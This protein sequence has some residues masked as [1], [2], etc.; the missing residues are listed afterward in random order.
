MKNDFTIAL[1]DQKFA[2]NRCNPFCRNALM[3]SGRDEKR[4]SLLEDNGFIESNGWMMREIV[5]I[6]TGIEADSAGFCLFDK[7]RP[8]FGIKGRLSSV[9]STSGTRR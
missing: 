3:M 1:H 5:E 4:G 2:L 8:R 7:P 9:S 6:G